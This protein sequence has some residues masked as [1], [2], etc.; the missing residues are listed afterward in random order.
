MPLNW[1]NLII[2]IYNNVGEQLMKL[3]FILRSLKLLLIFD[4]VIDLYN[5][6]LLDHPMHLT[7][8]YHVYKTV[9]IININHT[10]TELAININNH[11]YKELV[12]KINHTYK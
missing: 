3:Y 4:I 2:G 8:Q 12:I 10:Y 7:Y 9:F 11:A 1:G 6:N 5:I